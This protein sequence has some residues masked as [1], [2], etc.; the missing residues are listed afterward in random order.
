MKGLYY[1]PK[2]VT[3][4][5]STITDSGTYLAIKY[6]LELLEE[7]TP[8]VLDELREIY[9]IYAEADR[10]FRKHHKGS[11]LWPSEWGIVSQA[12]S[13]N[14]P[15]YIPLKEAI[16]AW[17]H[18]F[19]LLGESDFY[20]SLGLVSLSFF[21]NDCKESERKKRIN[22]YK[23][24][25][26]RYNVS[27]EVVRNSQRFRNTW[28]YEERLVLAEN[29][30]HED[31]PDNIEL[32]KSIDR[33]ESIHDSFFQTTNP[34]V[35]SPDTMLAYTKDKNEYMYEEIRNH[36]ELML[37]IYDRK[38]EEALQ[39]NEPFTLPSFTGLA[40]DPRTDTWQEF[41][42]RIDQAFA[43]YKEL[44]RKRAEDFLLSRGYVKEKEKRNLNHFKWLLHYQI[45]RWSLR[46]I[47]DYYSCSSDEIVQEDTVSH[48]IKSTANM[49]LLDLKQRKPM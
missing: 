2:R 25:A 11:Q 23:E 45:Q 42:N 31:E 8:E 20:K 15:N 49:V 6:F 5:G 32:S 39:K 19:N 44:Y 7:T 14:C 22:E 16:N 9:D 13:D 10:W 26:K 1:H 40:W 18:K 48:G 36:Y 47:A 28:P 38:K 4:G 30:F 29:V 34:F 27:L 24:L 12:S 17:A 37:S 33:G 35:F 43:E 41:E 3:Y 46:E 21:Y